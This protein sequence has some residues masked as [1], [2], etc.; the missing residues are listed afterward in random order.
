MILLLYIAYIRNRRRI[1]Y[2]LHS[3]LIL[4]YLQQ[5]KCFKQKKLKRRLRKLK[6]PH[7][8][9]PKQQHLPPRNHGPH[10]VREITDIDIFDTTGLFEDV[11]EWVYDQ[12]KDEIELPRNAP[13]FSRRKKTMLETRS[14]L[15]LVLQWLRHYPKYSILQQQYQVSKSYI[16]RDIKHIIPILYI[17]INL[18]K[19]P[20]E[21]KSSGRFDTHGSLDGTP[22]YRWR[23]HPGQAYYYRGDKHAHM[24]SAQVKII[25][26]LV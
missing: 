18:I 6:G 3:L 14:R 15:L 8:G 11:F 21:W 17:K 5:E 26:L 19:W 22:H 4:Q 2:L 25:I 9:K 16:T 13:L 10:L 1:V 12:V 20:T 23:V 7:K 24:L